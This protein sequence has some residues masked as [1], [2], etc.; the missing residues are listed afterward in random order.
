M[1]S[2]RPKSLVSRLKQECGL[3]RYK[4]QKAIELGKD[5]HNGVNDIMRKLDLGVDYGKAGYIYDMVRGGLKRIP[6]TAEPVHNE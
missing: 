6:K 1:E 4:A 3:S 5:P 2:K